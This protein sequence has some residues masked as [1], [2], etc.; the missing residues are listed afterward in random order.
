MDEQVNLET[1]VYVKNIKEDATEAT[2][3]E[4]F[5]QFGDVKTLSI[6]TVTFQESEK[7]FAM[8]DFASKEFAQR[9]I[10][11]GP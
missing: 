4:G 7:R 5:S 9:A 6:K 3:R 10:V 1:K 11:E 8:I 2:V